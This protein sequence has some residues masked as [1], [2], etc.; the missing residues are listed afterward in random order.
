M[1]D[2]PHDARSTGDIVADLRAAMERAREARESADFAAVH[3][4]HHAATYG[5]SVEVPA[6]YNVM[7]YVDWLRESMAGSGYAVIPSAY[8]PEKRY[9]APRHIVRWVGTNGA[10]KRACPHGWDAAWSD[11]TVEPIAE[12]DYLD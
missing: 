5:L 8:R 10:P 9:A 11:G 1:A 7:S 2:F 3:D 4:A 12:R 6:G